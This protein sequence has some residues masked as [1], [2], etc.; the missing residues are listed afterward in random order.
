MIVKTVDLFS[1]FF[2]D[3]DEI[4]VFLGEFVKFVW[5]GTTNVDKLPTGKTYCI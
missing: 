1:F 4:N 3:E 2:A 5:W